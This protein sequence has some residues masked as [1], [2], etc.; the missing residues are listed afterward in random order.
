MGASDATEVTHHGLLPDTSPP[1]AAALPRHAHSLP[2][3][4]TGGIFTAESPMK[5]NL[6]QR[7][8]LLAVIG[9][10]L[11]SVINHFTAKPQA[12]NQPAAQASSQAQ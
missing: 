2:T 10:V 6:L 9:I 7:L 12:G 8:A 5:L 1:V 3:G 11:A 4:R